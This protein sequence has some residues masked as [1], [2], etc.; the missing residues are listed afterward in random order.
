MTA[1]GGIRTGL[2][3]VLATC[4][5]WL[6]G[7]R[8]GLLT[9]HGGL[10]SALRWGPARLRAA[11]GVRLER[12]FAP[13]HGLYGDIPDRWPVAAGT[14]PATGLPVVSLFGADREKSRSQAAMVDGLDWV[15]VDLPDIGSRFYTFVGTALGLLAACAEAGVGMVVLDR[16][17]PLG[18]TVEGQRAVAPAM[19][20][21]IGA[22]PVPMR[23]GLTLGEMV[24]LGAGAAG[25]AHLVR[26]VPVEGWRRSMRWP[27]VG[28][29]WV[30]TSPAANSYAMAQCYPGTCLFEGTNL[31]EG[32]G[33]TS[34]FVQIG[35]PWLD[36]WRLAGELEGRLPAGVYARP[37]LFRPEWDKHAG[38]VCQ[39]V[40]LHT[41]PAVDIRALPAALHLLAATLRMAGTAFPPAKAG[42]VYP[43]PWFDLLAGDDRLRT[44]LLAG[45]PVEEILADWDADLRDWPDVRA[46]VSLYP[47]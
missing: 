19:R 32:R 11:G 25:L 31:S 42:E 36:A 29:P 20:S 9:N 47:D 4:P 27:D 44:D 37:A 23:H 2:D 12:L 18:G 6:A 22:L 40:M 43:W 33:T 35:A 17:N 1:A 7:A 34:P 24:R 45:R 5:P 8:V 15:L 41:D 30:P 21:L 26:V 10:D 14:D 28:R 3:Q 38:T 39:G 13:E 46:T 16:P